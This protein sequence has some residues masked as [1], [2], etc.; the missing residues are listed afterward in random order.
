MLSNQIAGDLFESIARDG[1]VSCKIKKLP[2]MPGNYTAGIIIRSNE[3]ILDWIQQA[4]TIVVEPG[5]FYGTGR[6]PPQ[7][8]SG[9]LLEQEW[10]LN[11]STP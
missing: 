4:V 11:G 6:M 1:Y 3:I 7:S 5:D 8:H 10:S 9:V 2:L